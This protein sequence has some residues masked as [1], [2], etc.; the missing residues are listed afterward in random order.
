[1]V[2]QCC[3]YN[4]ETWLLGRS[5]CCCCCFRS[6]DWRMPSKC[7]DNVDEKQRMRD[8]RSS[9]ILT[10]ASGCWEAATIDSPRLFY[11]QIKI[12]KTYL[13]GNTWSKI[14]WRHVPTPRSNNWWLT[15]FHILQL[16]ICLSS[17]IQNVRGFLVL[18]SRKHV[19]V[20]VFFTNDYSV[21]HFQVVDWTNFLY[22]PL[23]LT[24]VVTT[25]AS[26]F[27]CV[28]EPGLESS[29]LFQSKAKKYP[30][31]EH[32]WSHCAL[33]TACEVR[34][35]WSVFCSRVP[36]WEII[37]TGVK[38]ENYLKRIKRLVKSQ[39]NFYIIF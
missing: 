33:I 15:L 32:I 29:Y 30:D 13:V 21:R 26:L 14:I 16:Q 31:L 34:T 19:I 1:M 27:Q 5:C 37:M 22:L 3:W 2:H 24:L 7:W 12:K 10:T 20:S 25:V 23:S 35:V 6:R 11:K 9:K 18:T 38:Q 8:P 36:G 39:N 17:R 28:G 4:K